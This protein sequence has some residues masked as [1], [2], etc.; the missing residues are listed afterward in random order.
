MIL[1]VNDLQKVQEKVHSSWVP[2]E[3]G[4]IPTTISKMFLGFTADDYWKNW[5]TVFSSF[6]LFKHLPEID[7]RCWVHFVSACSLLSTTLINIRD[8]GV[9]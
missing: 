6:A 8:V 1:N 2:S 5:V 4:R 3:L 9:A 7:Y